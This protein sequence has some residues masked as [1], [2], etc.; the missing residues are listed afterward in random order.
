VKDN[1]VT[2]DA[3]TI[4]KEKNTEEMGFLQG[5]YGPSMCS[6]LSDPET[7]CIRHLIKRLDDC[8]RELSDLQEKGSFD[9]NHST[10]FLT[11]PQAFPKFAKMFER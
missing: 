3:A 7:I 5:W 1:D 9:L 10:H 2:G 8:H 11:R 4:V 6:R